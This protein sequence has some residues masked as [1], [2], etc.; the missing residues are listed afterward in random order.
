[1]MSAMGLKVEMKTID[2]QLNKGIS[3]VEYNNQ[4]VTAR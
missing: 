4:S 1:M 2:W 3:V